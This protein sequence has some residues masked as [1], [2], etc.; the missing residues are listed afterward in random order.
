MKRKRREHVLISEVREALQYLVAGGK[1]QSRQ[2]LVPIPGPHFNAIVTVT[3]DF[4][5]RENSRGVVLA[6]EVPAAL[7]NHSKLVEA[8]PELR[9]PA[10]NDD[11]DE[12]DE[13]GDD[14]E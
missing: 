7:V 13:Y 12:M 11:D 1:P 3:C 9:R 4:Q 10:L 6:E 8:H 5:R 2:Y 14:D